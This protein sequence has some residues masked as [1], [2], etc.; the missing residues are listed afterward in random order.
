MAAYRTRARRLTGFTLIEVLVSMVLFS[1]LLTTAMYGYQLYNS[2]W[3]RQLSAIDTAKADYQSLEMVQHSLLA[4]IPYQVATDN[5]KNAFYF[6]GR[7][8]GLTLVTA[9]PVFEPQH[10]AVIRLFREKDAEGGFQLVY[11]EASLRGMRLTSES[12]ELPFAHRLIVMK[13]IGKI[14]FKYLGWPDMASRTAS[15][16]SESLLK[17]QLF[18]Q[19]DGLVRGYQPKQIHI[20]LDEFQWVVPLVGRAEKMLEQQ[21]G[22]TE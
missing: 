2:L 10:P 12:Q 4:A 7:S 3:Q 1:I 22:L 21:Q 13:G 14:D 6:L 17:P 9:N 16:S 20:Q 8:E 11:E 19:Y 15:L 5:R 18:D